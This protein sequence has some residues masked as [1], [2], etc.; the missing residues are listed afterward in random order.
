ML[1]TS[2]ARVCMM[3]FRGSLGSE[4]VSPDPIPSEAFH[5]LSDSSFSSEK[6]SYLVS[7]YKHILQCFLYYSK[8][9][10]LY[11]SI[12]FFSPNLNPSVFSTANSSSW[13]LS[14]MACADLSRH[15]IFAKEYVDNCCPILKIS[16]EQSRINNCNY[17]CRRFP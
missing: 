4:I 9:S 5:F 14:A 10:C 3:T 16:I 1:R 8:P 11:S 7:L 17:A 2:R 15:R 13:G 12:V 6:L